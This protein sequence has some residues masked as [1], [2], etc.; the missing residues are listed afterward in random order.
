MYLKPRY[1][2]SM[3]R[4]PT[5]REEL[6]V[7]AFRTLWPLLS[8]IARLWRRTVARRTR[9]VTVVGS[10]GKTTTARVVG[11]VLCG[12]D[13]RVPDQNYHSYTAMGI[14]GIRRGDPHA[15]IEI[16]I[17][18]VGQMA[19]YASLIRP[20]VVVVTAIQSDHVGSLGPIEVTRREKFKMVRA[21]GPDG[22]A[23]L[24]GDDPN[25][26]WMARRTRAK[27]TTFGFDENCDVRATDVVLAEGLAGTRFRLHA[28]GESRDV[29][30]R[31]IGRPMVRI[32][33]SGVAAGLAEGLDLDT[34]LGRLEQVEPYPRRLQ[35]I[36]LPSGAM[37]LQDAHKSSLGTVEASLDAL[38]ELPARRRMLV[39][40]DVDD[41][42]GDEDKSSVYRQLGRRAAA[43]TERVVF[44]CGEWEADCLTG[45]VD[46]GMPPGAILCTGN[47]PLKAFEVLDDL[48]PGD[49]VLLKGRGSQHFERLV[50]L[51]EGRDFFC[52][53]PACRTRIF[54]CDECP[55]LM[56]GLGNCSFFISKAFPPP[57]GLDW[58]GTGRG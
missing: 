1:M 9:V 31:L 38:A 54:P 2:L 32:A 41:L 43:V 44:V 35:P 48:G 40:G 4:T 51:L 53:L 22:V 37:V 10:V 16:G 52:R 27:V 3:L 45:A 47:D 30:I 50:M 26:L 29:H 13:Y 14:L 18:G 8:P 25:V 17:S 46:A 33:L 20:D 24:N 56:H 6:R 36:H 58:R 34:I 23:V 12:N 7:G 11:A 28:A 19:M 21:L 42:P 5:G 55:A 15:V 49:V 57:P 39:L